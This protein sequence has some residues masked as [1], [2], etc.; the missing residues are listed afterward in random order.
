M[1]KPPYDPNQWLK[2]MG[3][4]AFQTT[5]TTESHEHDYLQFLEP[6]TIASLEEWKDRNRG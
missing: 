3:T 5:T 6:E 1:R 4:I 2:P